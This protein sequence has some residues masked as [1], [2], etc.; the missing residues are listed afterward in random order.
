MAWQSFSASVIG[1]SH[2]RHGKD[3]QDRA[4]NYDNQKLSLAV[5]A[6]G[7]GA[8]ECFRSA[9]GAELAA[10]CAIKALHDFIIELE[11]RFTS[12]FL[13]KA[14]PPSHEE[15]EKLLHGL[16]NH[17]VAQWHDGVDRHAEAESFTGSELAEAGEKYRARYEAG[18]QYA[19]A[20][21]ATL[22]AAAFT[23]QYWFG[24]HIGD[25][26]LTALYRD[27]AFDQP[28]PWDEKCFLNQT[29]S[30]CDDDAAERARVYFSFHNKKAPPV[31]VFLCSDGVDDNYPVDENERHLFKLYR[32][33]ALTFAEE[34]F[35]STV[36]QIKDLAA[37]FA[38]KGKGDDT[39]IAGLVDMDGIQRAA[40]HWR[41]QIAH[42]T[43]EDTGDTAQ[44]YGEFVKG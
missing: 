13:R 42:E 38:T 33:I 41:K 25:G 18:E 6:D 9:K 2:T 39:S 14:T 8:D 44:R 20:Y 28:V 24:L 37:S 4:G 12:S 29:T 19:K 16:V 35:P 27:G 3:I 21:G 30:M 32:T 5:I 40:P 23:K 7:H 43:G 36:K 34:G 11:P 15:F 10:R 31:A 22:I 17:I 26:R 1:S